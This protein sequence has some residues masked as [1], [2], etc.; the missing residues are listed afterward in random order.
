MKTDVKYAGSSYA[1]PHNIEKF[2]NLVWNHVILFILNVYGCHGVWYHVD[3]FTFGCNIKDEKDQGLLQ[4]FI[5]CVDILVKI[6]L[7][8]TEKL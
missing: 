5:K 2:D 8:F 4:V 6:A 7:R 1:A 3:P